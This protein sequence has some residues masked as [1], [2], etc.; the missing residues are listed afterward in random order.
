MSLRIFNSQSQKKEDFK[1]IEPNKVRMYVCGPTVYDLLHVGNFRGA[2]F[3]NL[4]RSWLEYRGYSVNFIYNYTDVDD[5][6]ISRAQKDGVDS[7]EISE[8]YIQEFEK[9]FNRL[10]LKKHSRNPK[11]TEFMNPIIEFVNTLVE[12]GHAYQVDGDVYFDVHSLP[13]YGRLS[14]K[15]LEDLEAGVRIGVDE[16]KKHAAD[17]ALWKSAKPGEPFWPSPWGD[18]R[19]GWHIECSAMA[20][21]LLGDTIDIHGGGLDL[22]FPHHENEVAQSEGATGKPFVRYWMHNNMLNFGSQKM[23]KSLGNVRS[24]RDFMTEY[25]AEIFKYLMLSSHYRSVLDFSPAAID[26]S[27][28]GLARIYSALCQADRILNSADAGKLDEKGSE[29]FEKFKTSVGVAF[30]DD[31]NTPEALARLFEII[32]QFNGV[33]R[34]PGKVTPQKQAAALLLSACSNWLGEM[35]SLFQEP[36]GEFLNLLDDMLLRK[37]GLE[38][39]QIDKLVAERSVARSSKNFAESDRLRDELVRLGIQVQDGVGESHWEVL[40]S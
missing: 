5:K 27:I 11:V 8:R 33:A 18:G 29:E 22:I 25:N 21:T 1:T 17:F 32:R 30:D 37:K 38:R 23:S 12:R 26:N 40:K 34:V 7:N 19:P 20:R 31:F 39:S 35:M 3:F 4:V 24:A 10:K 14:H 2:I 6:I 15:K 9:D 36:A 16:R 28:S 13:E